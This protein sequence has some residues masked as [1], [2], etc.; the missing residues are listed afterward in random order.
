MQGARIRRPLSSSN[1]SRRITLCRSISS[2]SLVESRPSRST[3]VAATAVSLRNWQQTFPER[4]YLGIE[5]LG[6]RVQRGCKKAARPGGSQPAVF[7]HRKHLRDGI[8]AAARFGRSR[9]SA[10]SRSM[11]EDENTSAGES[12]NRP[13]L[14]RCIAYSD[15]TGVS[16]SRPTRNTISTPFASLL[17]P[18]AFVEKARS[19]NESLP[20]TTF[21]RHFVAEGAPI[22]RLELRKVS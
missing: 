12:S 16:A 1:C 3:S 17:S 22:Y 15:R 10:F 20:V 13:F 11:A 19:P 4:N 7:A 2:R 8:P 18:A 6:G 5:K 14:S 9:A 21:E